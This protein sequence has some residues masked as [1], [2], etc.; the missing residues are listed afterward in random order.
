MTKTRLMTAAV[1]AAGAGDAARRAGCR[2]GPAPRASTMPACSPPTQEPGQWMGPGRTYD[3]QHFSPLDADQRRQRRPGS[4]SPGSPTSPPPAGWKRARWRSTACCTTS[5]R[6]TWSPPTTAGPARCCGPTTLKFP[7]RFGRLACCDIVSRG[8]AAWQGKIY[9]ATLDGRLI[10]LDAQDRQA[11]VVDADGRQFEELHDHRRAAGVR[12]Q[13]ADRQRRR[14]GR[15]ARLR[16]APM[17]PRPASCCGAFYTVPG[18]PADGFENAGD[19]NGRE[20]LDRRVVEG[21]RRRHRVGRDHLRSRRS[22][23]VY[24]GTGNGSP[25]VRKWR[26]PGGGDNLFLAS[27]VALDAEDRRLQAGTTRRCPARSGTIPPP[28]R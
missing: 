7:L 1:L 3:E 28:S 10:A 15:R 27:I 4:A 23:T 19:G 12:R 20:D 13:G 24:I 8:L 22:S 14:R 17:T 2:T 5:S 18:N 9:V 11:G 21:R 26:S 16:L 25:W 6:G